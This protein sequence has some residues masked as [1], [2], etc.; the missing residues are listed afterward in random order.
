MAEHRLIADFGASGLGWPSDD[1]VPFAN[2]FNALNASG[3]RGIP[4][5]GK[6][7]L[8]QIKTLLGPRGALFTGGGVRIDGEGHCGWPMMGRGSIFQLVDTGLFGAAQ[9]DAISVQAV[10]PHYVNPATGA[11][12][13][14]PAGTGGV[15]F[16]DDIAGGSALTG[17]VGSVFR[18]IAILQADIAFQTKN[19]YSWT[20]DNLQSS[21]HVTSGAYLENIHVPGSGDNSLINSTFTSQ[22][23]AHVHLLSGGG[24]KSVNNKLNGGYI[25]YLINYTGA[26]TTQ[27]ISPLAII[28]GSVEGNAGCSVLMQRAAG[29]ELVGNLTFNGVEFQCGILAQG[30]GPTP[31]IQN[32]AITGC[33]IG[34]SPLSRAC[35]AV[36]GWDGLIVDGNMLVAAPLPAAIGVMV[37]AATAHI[38]VGTNNKGA[39]VT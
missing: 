32:G 35:V 30:S 28:G 27:G 34:A 21:G 5:V 33:Y 31:W 14:A 38:T 20:V 18:D 36:D 22:P 25:G 11:N 24:F 19:G 23:N 9:V 3:G 4:E 1:S 12:A 17:N 8:P 13:N 2:W 26:V 6:F 39:G 7:Y 37:G 10:G 29:T 15:I 16:L